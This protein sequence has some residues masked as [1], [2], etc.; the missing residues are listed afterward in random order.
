MNFCQVELLSQVGVCTDRG[1]VQCVNDREKLVN[2]TLEDFSSIVQSDT[3]V[4]V[5][6]WCVD[7]VSENTEI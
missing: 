4:V 5:N 3:A 2:T 6:I 7:V 1:P